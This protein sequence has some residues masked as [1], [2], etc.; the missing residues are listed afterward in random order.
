MG[1]GSEKNSYGSTTLGGG[2]RKDGGGRR[3][4]E[5]GRRKDGGG[6]TEEEGRRRKDGGGRTEEEGRRR[7]DGGGRRK[8]GGERT[9]EEGQRREEEGGRT[10]GGGGRTEE[11]GGRR[12]ENNLDFIC[13][14]VVHF[15]GPQKF[16]DVC[17]LIFDISKKYL[18]KYFM[19][20]DHNHLFRT[21]TKNKILCNTISNLIQNNL[22]FICNIVV[23]FLG[24]QKIWG[25]LLFFLKLLKC[26]ILPLKW[27]SSEQ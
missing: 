11:I 19:Q 4:D 27:L 12:E 22:V 6:R 7:K 5:G 16:E 23:S 15:L 9:E 25:H 24:P 18:C 26:S 17:N 21:R 8:N 2:R 20:T 14:I 1:S 3:E 10:E 13:N